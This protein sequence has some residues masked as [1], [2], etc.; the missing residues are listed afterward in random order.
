MKVFNDIHYKTIRKK[1]RNNMTPAEIQLWYYLKDKK[2][3]GHK[4]RRQQG[5]SRFIVD[6]YCPEE[7]L[8][9][10][11]DGAIHFRPDVARKDLVRS[12]ILNALGINILRFQNNEVFYNI[13]HVL[14]KIRSV[15][16]GQTAPTPS[17]ERR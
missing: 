6:F 16:T 13:D 10:E 4:F 15:F 8:A 5:I 7:K 11:L 1:L 3:D 9:I 2:L 12:K 14:G 17:A